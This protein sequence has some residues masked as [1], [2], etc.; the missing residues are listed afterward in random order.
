MKARQWTAARQAG[1]PDAGTVRR[2]PTRAAGAAALAAGA[3]VA[4]LAAPAQAQA[5]PANTVPD[6]PGVPA[7]VRGLQGPVVTYPTESPRDYPAGE[8]CA[9]PTHTEF[10]VSDLRMRTWT[11]SAGTPV[12]A[13]E[14]GPLLMRV[15]N[16]DTGRTIVRDISG[17]GVITYPTPDSYILSGND[18]SAGFHTT[19]RPVHNKWIV[20]STFMSVKITTVDGRTSREL[21]ALIGPYEDICATLS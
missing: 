15:T 17:T 2:T 20:A 6:L 19:D 3:L 5:A 21:L 8:V 18:W 10:P 9:F 4:V 13:I 14:D 7:N 11:D 16:V 1:T 12:F